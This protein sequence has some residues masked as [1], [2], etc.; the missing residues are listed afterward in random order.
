MQTD[1]TT[2]A[3]QVTAA[4]PPPRSAW[5]TRIIIV[6]VLVVGLVL[7][8][9]VLLALHSA[10][11]R[12]TVQDSVTTLRTKHNALP[13][14]VGTPDRAAPSGMAPPGP[15][16]KGAS[17]MRGYR[18]VYATDFGGSSLPSGWEYF[19]GIPGGVPSGQFARSHVIVS[20]GMLQLNTWQDPVYDNKWVT[21]GLC[22]CGLPFHYGAFF[23]RSR[24]T[25][26]G[27]N[28][29][30][31]LWPVSNKWPPEIDFNETG[32][33]DTSTSWTV[34]YG[35]YNSIFQR[36]LNI[37]MAQ[38]H[39]WGII[40]TPTALVF[41]VDGTTWG[42][43]TDPSVIPN[44]PMTLDLQQRPA[45]SSGTVCTASEQSMYVDWVAE[46]QKA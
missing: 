14:V 21:G 1:V 2:V 30:E 38:W 16:P 32:N 8:A 42:T 10:L 20:G 29:V 25:G 31:L 9:V 27:P 44:V 6:I 39:T 18:R 19:T 36:T 24:I 41:T 17:A 13:Y 34:H 33:E 45:C 23:V 28:E 11:P 3:P 12:N 5:E 7:S 22:Q 4:P 46:Y 40:W 43:F 35:Q 15:I 26:P 37:N